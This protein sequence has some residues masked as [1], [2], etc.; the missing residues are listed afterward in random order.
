VIPTL[1]LAL[2][3]ERRL[4]LSA[5]H[6]S[7]TM[8]QAADELPGWASRVIDALPT[9]SLGL[10]AKVFLA[11]FPLIFAPT[12]LVLFAV[13]AEV[14]SLVG[15]AV[16]IDW[17]LTDVGR[18]LAFAGLGFVGWTVFMLLMSVALGLI[19]IAGQAETQ[20]EAEGGQPPERTS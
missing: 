8:K 6:L 9:I 11:I 17:I 1:L 18:G 10:T 4:L 15:V 5:V 3:L 2:V 7:K 20:E 13:A 12:V 14:I 19:G 16:P